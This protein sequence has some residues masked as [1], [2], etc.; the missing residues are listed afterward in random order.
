[1]KKKIYLISLA[2]FC[3]I[4]LTNAQQK[5]VIH[6]N[7]FVGNKSMKVSKETLNTI[8]SKI[9][10]KQSNTSEDTLRRWYNY[11][12]AMDLFIGGPGESSLYWDYL[13]PDTTMKGYYGSNLYN[14]WVH[15]AANALDVTSDRFN[16]E[17]LF[18]EEELFLTKDDNF[19]L[20]SLGIV[21]HYERNIEDESIVDTLE[22]ELYMVDRSNWWFYGQGNSVSTNLQSDS[23]VWIGIDYDHTNNN[24]NY[25]AKKTYKILLTNESFEAS[26][27]DNGYHYMEIATTDFPE[28]DPN[29][30]VLSSVKF[31]PGYTWTAGE[32]LNEKNYAGILSFNENGDW[33]T[34]Y[35]LTYE[36]WDMNVSYIIPTNV[37]YNNGGSWNGYYNPSFAFMWQPLSTYDYVLEHHLIYYNVS[38][39]NTT[40]SINKT[41]EKKSNTRLYPNPSSEIVNVVSSLSQENKNVEIYNS[42]GKLC[43][44]AALVENQGTLQTEI[45]VNSLKP[46]LYFVKVGN[47]CKKLIIE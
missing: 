20:D 37:R 14:P 9:N 18:S 32:V 10:K 30:L 41:V 38:K 33:N 8:K 17:N 25:G 16:D 40:V 42:L 6:Q 23:V 43:I 21:F 22:V 28:V 1:M 47:E 12:D 27:L 11:G 15:S 39:V 19:R 7:N 5:S 2:I 31:I 36:K 45:N 34:P 29:Y 24:M 26:Q 4:S 13:F 3:A 46:G 35:F 44:S